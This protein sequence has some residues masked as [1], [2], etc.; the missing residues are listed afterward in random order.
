MQN[1]KIKECE[2]QAEEFNVTNT[3]KRTL[4]T[5]IENIFLS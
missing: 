2:I 5:S 3:S 1:E 4:I